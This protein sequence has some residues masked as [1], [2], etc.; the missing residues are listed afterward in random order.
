MIMGNKHLLI[1]FIIMLLDISGYTQNSF[2]IVLESGGES[3]CVVSNL[4]ETS[5]GNYL[6]SYT[7]QQFADTLVG[8]NEYL[9]EISPEGD[10]ATHLFQK[11]DTIIYFTKIF[12]VSENPIK[13]FVSGM[14]FHHQDDRWKFEI[15]MLIDES[16]NIIWEKR[17]KLSSIKSGYSSDD[18][19]QLADGSFLYARM[20]D[21]FQQYMYL[22]HLSADGDSL[23]YRVFEGDSAGKVMSLTY[24]PDSSSYWLH[25][26]LAHYDQTGPESQVI[27]LSETFEQS[28]IIY[29]PRWFSENYY[30]KV[31]PGNILVAGGNYNDFNVNYLSTY[32]LDP[33]LNVLYEDYISHPDTNLATTGQCV[34]YY[35]S[36]QIY[37][38]GT[39]NRSLW[40]EH[41]SWFVIAK[42][43]QDLNLVYEKYLGG[44]AN[45]WLHH[46]T[47]TSD[48]GVIISGT[49]YDYEEPI[50]RKKAIV[51]KLNTDG[52]LVNSNSNTKP[53]IKQSTAIVYPN[54]GKDKMILRTF[55]KER[56]FELFDVKGNMCL[57]GY[58]NELVTTYNTSKLK[59]GIY[60]WKIS[61]AQHDYESGIWI[62]Q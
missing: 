14:F 2:E 59:P 60:T 52:I 37:I 26:H 13:Y 12:Q 9:V 1:C 54:P 11:Q 45:Y 33:G 32:V 23:D 20:A 8:W 43:D 51:I 47:A 53:F 48:S 38:G 61:G 3:Y 39:H 24:S 27:E 21:A 50:T 36:D 25:S 29:Y 42:Y 49:K 18:I 41:P 46:I 10:T 55:Q 44:D 4:I 19:M 31:L 57:E 62:K 5:E 40:G 15:F 7:H 28:R 17:Y 56:K 6:G 30:A 58:T 34:D 16:F 22:F 35:Y